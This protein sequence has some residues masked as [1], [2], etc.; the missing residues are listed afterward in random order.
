MTK[1][2]PKGAV[3]GC[4]TYIDRGEYLLPIAKKY[5]RDPSD[6][7]LKISFSFHLKPGKTL[8]TSGW[9][10][11]H[12]PVLDCARI[13]NICYWHGLAPRVYS[14]DIIDW[15]GAKTIAQL[16]DYAG[17]GEPHNTPLFRKVCNVIEEYGGF[18]VFSKEDGGTWNS[19]GG[20]WVGFKGAGFRDIA[21]YKKKIDGMRGTEACRHHANYK[22]EFNL[23]F[24]D[25]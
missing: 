11:S 12:L 8:E 1:E 2:K 25:H 16:Q 5:R 18:H 24:K 9:G 15:Q 20:K 7:C 22:G 21:I 14:V 23:D 17:E 3:G 19:A 13:Q 10:G 4:H 6:L